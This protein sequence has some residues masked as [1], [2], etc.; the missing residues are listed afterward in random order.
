[1]R[2]TVLYIIHTGEDTRRAVLC[3]YIQTGAEMTRAI[4]YRYIYTHTHKHTHA[5]EGTRR[6]VLFRYINTGEGMRR[7]ILCVYICIHRCTSACCFMNRSA[8]AGTRRS[9]KTR[10]PSTQVRT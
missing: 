9:E 3:V 2:R 1:M 7:A 5:G 6:A 4:L 8:S 10:K